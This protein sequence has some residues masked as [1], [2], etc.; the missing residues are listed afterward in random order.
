MNNVQLEILNELKKHTAYYERM[1][2]K[3]WMI[4]KMIE[5]IA[6]ENGYVFE[7]NSETEKTESVESQPKYTRDWGLD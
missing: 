7:V 2:W 3:L 4:Q 5:S 1:D 6:K